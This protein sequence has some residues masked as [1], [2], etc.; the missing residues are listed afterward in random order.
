[1]KNRVVGLNALN[2]RTIRANTALRALSRREV[3]R[4]RRRALI[5]S[6]G[7]VFELFLRLGII[8]WLLNQITRKDCAR[9]L[10]HRTQT[11]RL[12][13][14]DSDAVARSALRCLSQDGL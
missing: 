14:G 13:C 4:G 5:S 10:K 7:G 8:V 12:G 1:M 2:G 9:T 6:L 11:L 3:K